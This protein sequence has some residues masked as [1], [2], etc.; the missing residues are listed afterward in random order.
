MKHIILCADDYGQ[1]L[2]VSQAIID[3]LKQKRLSATSCMT[4]GAQ[5]ISHARMLQIFADEVDTGLHFN[6]TEGT[7]LSEAYLRKY[8]K[9]FMSLPKLIILASIRL[10]DKNTIE[11][12]LEAQLEQFVV[13]MGRE[14]DFID[15]HQ[16]IHQ[17]PIIRE[18]LITVYERRYK[19]KKPYIRS[20]DQKVKPQKHFFKQ[21]IIQLLGARALKRKLVQKNI[22]HNNSFEGI[23]P[24]SAHPPYSKNFRGFLERVEE[25]GIIM[26]HP[27]LEGD[28]KI[29]PIAAARYREYQYFS[30]EQFL[31]DCE[32]EKVALFEPSVL[33]EG[34]I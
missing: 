17:F 9:T 12:E 24:F 18:A 20:T 19:N 11:K 28:L 13:G 29:D 26:C 3:L 30:S 4:T 23:Y 8:G 15:G 14:P 32:K 27:G 6:L 16:H 34:I 10:L 21:L 5:W 7:P 25:G 33:N 1:S 22:P 31:K 2:P